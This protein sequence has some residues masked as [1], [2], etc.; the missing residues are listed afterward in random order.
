MVD[1]TRDEMRDLLNGLGDRLSGNMSGRSNPMSSPSSGGAGILS[2][3]TGALGTAIDTAKGAFTGVSKAVTEVLTP[4]QQLSGSGIAFNNDA[5]GLLA[6]VKQT[7]MSQEQWEA[8]MKT[9]ALGM[10]AFGGSMSDGARAVTQFQVDFANTDAT[11][12]LQAMGYTAAETNEVLALSL[13]GKKR[14]DLEDRESKQAAMIAA[15]SLATEMDAVAKLTGVSRKEQ[16][17]AL[18]ASMHNAR[19]RIAVEQAVAAGGEGARDA[20]KNLNAEMTGMGLKDFADN[21]YA[22]NAKT[23]ETIDMQNALGPAG[24]QLES[25][26]NASKNAHTEGERESAKLAVQQAQ[27]AVSARMAESSFQSLVK[28]GLGPV[29]DAA[30]KLY[31]STMNQTDA[32]KA[33]QEEEF[34]NTGIRLSTEQALAKAKENIANEQAG[35]AHNGADV[36]GAKTTQAMTQGLRAVTDQVA[37]FGKELDK[38]NTRIGGSK[39]VKGVIDETK[40]IKTDKAGKTTS[41][42][43][44]GIATHAADLIQNLIKDPKKAGEQ[45]IN[46]TEIKAKE[47]YVDYIKPG[48]NFVAEQLNVAKPFE[49]GQPAIP[50]EAEQ[51]NVAKPFEAGQPAIPHEAEGSKSVWGDWFA[52]PKNAVSYLRED[53]PEATVPK[54]KLDEFLK[55]MM[56]SMVGMSGINPGNYAEL[57][58]LAEKSVKPLDNSPE[59]I[60]ARINENQKAFAT[61][62]AG[63]SATASHDELRAGLGEQLK[64]VQKPPTPVQPLPPPPAK[65]EE[66][67]AETHKASLDDLREELVNLNKSMVKLISSSIESV[68]LTTQQVRA[69]KQLSPNMNV[70]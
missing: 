3:S 68:S 6:G 70:R 42:M 47:I 19:T 27:A 16:Q 7:R 53:E 66:K 31:L 55:D 45:L 41:Q 18:D 46:A 30:G 9:S 61:G 58:E 24:T 20:Y 8:T 54:S 49:A 10:T 12:K 2:G 32:I 33:V 43:D 4:W 28:T 69:T 35:K 48:V 38:A 26:I 14:S 50:H 39:L 5:I 62:T 60:Q 40:N 57:A 1:I 59:A 44:R 67:P 51:L 65:P 34:K 17:T 29:S 52:G 22:G 13:I 11:D 25:A 63:K 23:K 37:S 36:E 56:P 15:E 21:I 64:T